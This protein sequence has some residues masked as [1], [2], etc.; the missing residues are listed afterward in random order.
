M[1]TQNLKKSISSE[2][3]IFVLFA[4]IALAS[5]LVSHSWNFTAILAVSFAFSL[6]YPKA[7]LKTLLL[8][9]TVMLVSDI[10]IGFHTTMVF[11]YGGLV[12]GLAS[13][14]VLK[15]QSFLNKVLGVVSGSLIFFLVSNFGVWLMEG[16]YPMTT[17]GL[18][19]CFI[20]GIPFYKNQFLADVALTPIFFYLGKFIAN[21]VFTTHLQTQPKK[22]Q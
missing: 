4:F 22:I 9:L 12:L 3:L 11:V 20:M 16:L 8:P 13:I 7:R 2:N 15:P 14:L 19:Q 6:L 21:Q 18:A 1:F 10:V 5:R 17:Q